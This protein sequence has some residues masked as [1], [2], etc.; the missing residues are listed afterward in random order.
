MT[1]DMQIGRETYTIENQGSFLHD[2][3]VI[4]LVQ[5]D[6]LLWMYTTVT[7]WKAL[8]GSERCNNA[9][10]EETWTLDSSNKETWGTYTVKHSSMIWNRVIMAEFIAKTCIFLQSRCM[11]KRV[12]IVTCSKSCILLFSTPIA[13]TVDSRE[14]LQRKPSTTKASPDADS[15]TRK[16]VLW[17]NTERPRTQN[18]VWRK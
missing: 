13:L 5:Q 11:W 4:E 6:C 15:V 16:D 7:R 8:N 3:D 14:S 9:A 12:V 1:D 10:I 2:Q 17:T 18:Q